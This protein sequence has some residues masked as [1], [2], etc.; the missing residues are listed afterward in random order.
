MGLGGGLVAKLPQHTHG[1]VAEL[2]VFVGFL[3]FV[4]VE[5]DFDEDAGFVAIEHGVF[6]FVGAVGFTFA[7]GRGHDEGLQHFAAGQILQNQAFLHVLGHIAAHVL[8]GV[9]GHIGYAAIGVDVNLVFEF[10]IVDQIEFEQKLTE[11]GGH[12]V[13]LCVPAIAAVGGHYS[14][15]AD[16]KA[17]AAAYFW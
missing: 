7:V 8:E 14:Q 17:I 10:E 1:Q 16:A 6:N 2:A 9:G 11:V 3:D 5:P 13:S 4:F 15:S 12:D